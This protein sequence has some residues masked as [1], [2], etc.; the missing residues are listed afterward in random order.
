MFENN[1]YIAQNHSILLGKPHIKGTR[2]SVELILRKMSEGA[3]IS[4]I[5]DMYPNLTVN[6]V[7]A[8]LENN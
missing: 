8:C 6:Q 1:T 4:N 5:L 2:I 3:S 7:L